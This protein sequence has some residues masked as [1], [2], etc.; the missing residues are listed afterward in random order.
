MSGELIIENNGRVRVI[1]INRPEVRNALTDRLAWDIVLAVED[2]A[3]DD[4]VWVVGIT[5]AGGAFCA[6]LDLRDRTAGG[7]GPLSEMDQALDDIGWV[8]R[9]LLSLREVCDKPVIAGINGPAAGAGLALAMACDMRLMAESASLIPG[10]PRIG[11]PPDG[12]LTLTLQ[13]ALGYERTMRFLLENQSVTAAEALELGLVGEVVPDERFADRFAEY[14]DF[15]AE[16]API[17][18]RLTKRAV[19]RAWNL[20]L[21]DH[22]R[23]ELANIRRAF[24]SEDSREAI[25]AFLDKREPEFKGR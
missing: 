13:Q 25:Q 5:G 4:D 10:Y 17:A 2:A 15:I 21:T 24:A 11:A 3:R 18:S 1:R 22:V 7:S 12:G 9:F 14:C 23:Y 8:G 6:G 20:D 19:V 16:R